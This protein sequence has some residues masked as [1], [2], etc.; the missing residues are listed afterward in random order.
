MDEIVLFM[1]TYS[2]DIFCIVETWLDY[3]FP[4]SY[5]YVDRYVAHRADRP[6]GKIGGGLCCYVRSELSSD[7]LFDKSDNKNIEILIVRISTPAIRIIAVNL[8]FPNGSTLNSKDVEACYK[9]IISILESI[10]ST[11]HN[12]SVI[13]LGDFNRVNPASLDIN[14]SVKNVVNIPTRGDAILDLVLIPENIIEYYEPPSSMPPIGLSDHNVVSVLPRRNF[15]Y[16]KQWKKV[17]DLRE[18]KLLPLIKELHEIDWINLFGN[19]S[20]DDMC[21]V[22]YEVLYTLLARLHCDFVKRTPKDPPWMTGVIKVLINKR[23][24]AYRSKNFQL[25]N[26]YK[27]KVRSAI[28]DSKRNWGLMMSKKHGIWDIYNKVVGKNSSN[29]LT[30]CDTDSPTV[31]LLEK[32]K[33]NLISNCVRSSEESECP[34]FPFVVPFQV[35]EQEVFKMLNLVNPRKST[36]SDHIPSL[37]WSKLSDT[38]CTPLCY[39]YNKCLEQA[40]LPSRWKIADIVPLPKSSPP[41][42]DNVRPISL[43]PVP[44]RI[45]EKCVLNR[46]RNSFLQRYDINQFAYRPKSSTVCA[47]I[48]MVD[49]IASGLQDRSVSACHLASLDLAKGFDRVTRHLLVSKM[50][51]DNFDGFLVTLISNYMKSRQIRV[52]WKNEVSSCSTVSSG[53][54]QGSSIGPILFAYFVSDLTLQC[55]DCK[56]VKYADDVFL[57]STLR[58]DFCTSPLVHALVD[59]NRWALSNSMVIKSE[60]SKQ[61]IFRKSSFENKSSFSLTDIPMMRQL[62]ILGILFDENLKWNSH[63]MEMCKKASSKMYVL[64]QL[65]PFITKELLIQI[66]QSC[67]RSVL[68][69]GAPLFPGLNVGLSYEIDKIQNRAHRIICETWHCD[70]HNFVPLTYRRKIIGYRL[71]L[72][73]MSDSTHPMHSLLLPRLQFSGQFQLPKLT[74]TAFEQSFFINM[75]KMYNSGFTI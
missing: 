59:V 35:S 72:E 7:T 24:E 17:L 53:I 8:Y 51:R 69:Y 32:I 58:N 9:Y 20:L 65:K 68:E 75:S 60:K 30:N 64:R 3:T 36:G 42:I 54:P 28:I 34:P 2:P 40:D 61:M 25:Y 38:L 37:L 13:F 18:S 21:N 12:Y 73:I 63:V 41:K 62:R 26:H 19:R 46:I 67:V 45:F 4:N 15:V 70:C 52:R 1:N 55:S 27:W 11:H 16:N 10:L 48:E 43:L 66:Y 49:F 50:I 14:F 39:I 29:W 23:F 5:I 71:F 56:M 33:Y 47:L 74:S 44:E 6:T 31:D 57:M 22:F